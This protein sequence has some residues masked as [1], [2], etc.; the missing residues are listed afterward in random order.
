MRAAGI[1]VEVFPDP[2]KLGQQLKYADR[3]GFRVALIAGG[4]EFQAGVCQVKDLQTG[5]KQDVPLEADAASLIAAVQTIL[6]R[7]L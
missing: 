6:G 5:I 4:N 7:A 2:K 3:R 1:G